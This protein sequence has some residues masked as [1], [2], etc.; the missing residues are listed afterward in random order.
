MKH[1]LKKSILI[2][3]VVVLAI[4]AA[5]AL[6]PDDKQSS[7]NSEQQAIQALTKLGIPLQRD[8]RGSVRWIE[9]TEG[10][11]SDEAMQYLPDL[12]WLEWLE[13]GK[14]SVSAAGTSKLKGCTELR[15]LYIHNINLTG[16]GLEWAPG[17]K[18]LEALSLQHTVIDGKALRNLLGLPALVVLNISENNIRDEDMEHIAAL[19]NLEV[20]AL[21]NT[22]ITGAGIAKLEG[23]SRLNELNIV[24]CSIQDGD[25]EYF[26]TMPNL[27]I[28][29]AAGC[30]LNDMAIQQ[31]ISRF[32]M[33]AIFR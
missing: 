13:I 4:G 5:H 19:K 25:L 24:N 22:K 26:L 2:T 10:E 6:S 31:T 27:R 16:D 8:S 21:G 30:Y 29:Y 28:V 3:A 23:M 14:G 15:R 18:K 32:P 20:L 7:Q 12:P 9:A 33:L 11:F 1:L 17:L